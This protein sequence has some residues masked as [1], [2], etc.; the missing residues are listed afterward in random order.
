ML[1]KPL[2]SE[3][4]FYTSCW[5]LQ[6]KCWHRGASLNQI[7][8][9]LWR[10]KL[11]GLYPCVAATWGR[12]DVGKTSTA[13]EVPKGLGQRTL[14][15]APLQPLFFGGPG[16]NA[17]VETSG[18]MGPVAGLGR[19]TPLTLLL[20]PLSNVRLCFPETTATRDLLEK[21]RNAAFL[22]EEIAASARCECA[23]FLYPWSNLDQIQSLSNCIVQTRY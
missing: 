17:D 2:S 18:Q 9:F 1:G 21:Q 20:Q 7:I 3:D 11:P 16:G 5:N 22:A 23:V 10:C 8:I 12:R 13:K 6:A 15:P 4:R 14:L 19:F